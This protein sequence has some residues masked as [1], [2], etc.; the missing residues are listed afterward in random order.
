M[1][2]EHD[3]GDGRHSQG[4]PGTDAGSIPLEL[5]ETG[6]QDRWETRGHD[7]GGTDAGSIPRE[8]GVRDDAREGRELH[9]R[10]GDR[11]VGTDA[12]SIPRE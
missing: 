3:H 2:N 1:A 11:G 6:D 7:G 12:G 10:A 5:P 8:L 4:G 9:G